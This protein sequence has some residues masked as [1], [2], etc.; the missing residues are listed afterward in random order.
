MVVAERVAS[1]F[2]RGFIKPASRKNAPRRFYAHHRG[3]G[4]SI[5]DRSAALEAG[6]GPVVDVTLAGDVVRRHAVVRQVDDYIFPATPAELVCVIPKR[7]ADAF[8]VIQQTYLTAYELR[9]PN[10]HR[11]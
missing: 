4:S 9:D 7:L 3:A 5:L 10:R 8:D 11:I 2:S 6:F 1:C